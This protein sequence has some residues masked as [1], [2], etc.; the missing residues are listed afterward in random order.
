[1]IKRFLILFLLF[2]VTAFSGE[3]LTG[4]V[5]KITDG[6]TVH[7]QLTDKKVK[8]RLYGIDAPESKQEYGQESKKLLASLIAS[9]EVYVYVINTDRYGRLVGKIFCDGQYINAILVRDGAAWWYKQY[10]AK[11]IELT[12]AEKWARENKLGLWGKSNPMAPWKWRK[13]NK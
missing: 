2:T 6:D 1:M 9:K 12:I 13:K 4:K 5:V 11:E 10:A 7:V 8:I 3:L